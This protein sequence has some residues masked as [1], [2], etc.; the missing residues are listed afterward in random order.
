MLNY[1]TASVWPFLDAYILPLFETMQLWALFEIKINKY[2]L[3]NNEAYVF[4]LKELAKKIQKRGQL[5]DNDD[6]KPLVQ[7]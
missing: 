5:I 2:A 1:D 7:T 4:P 6:K 3:E